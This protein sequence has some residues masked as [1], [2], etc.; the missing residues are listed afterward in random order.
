MPCR[1]ADEQSN[2]KRSLRQGRRLRTAAVYWPEAQLVGVD[3]AAWMVNPQ[4]TFKITAAETLPVPDQSADVELNSLSLHYWVDHQKGLHEIA[5][6]LRPSGYFCL[7][8][9][10]SRTSNQ[11]NAATSRQ[12]RL[13]ETFYERVDLNRTNNGPTPNQRSL[14]N[15]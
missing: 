7:A 8:N 6:V 13:Q 4:A 3:P 9:R 2:A 12:S 11:T 14:L 10:D 1:L 5:R 15:G